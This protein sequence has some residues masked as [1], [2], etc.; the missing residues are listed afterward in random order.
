M[1]RLITDDE[2]KDAVATPPS[3]TRAYFRGMCLARFAARHRRRVV[4]LGDLRPARPRL[5]A[6][7]P[8][9]GAAA[10][11]QG[12]RR[13]LVRDAATPPAS[14]SRRI[15]VDNAS[16]ATRLPAANDASQRRSLSAALC[17][18][19][20]LLVSAALL[21]KS[22]PVEPH[23]E[24][25]PTPTTTMTPVKPVAEPVAPR[26]DRVVASTSPRPGS[27]TSPSRPASA[28]WHSRRT[29][30][31]P[32]ASP[33]SNRQCHVG[34]TTLAGIGAIESGHGTH[35][36]SRLHADGTTSRPILGPALD[37]SSGTARI[38]SDEQSEKVARRLQ[39]GTTPSGPMQFI[40]STWRKWGSDGN[41]RRHGRPQQ[42]R[43]TRPIRPA[44][45]C[46]PRAAT[47]GPARDGRRRSSPTTT[48]RTTC[49][50]S[51][52]APTRTSSRSRSVGR[53]GAV[54][55]NPA[56]P[57]PADASA[58]YSTGCQRRCV[59]ALDAT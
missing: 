21:A 28:R 34:W 50:A 47:C 48:P 39:A 10:R 42:R 54:S 2:I 53:A 43:S 11:H 25:A 58:G 44:A 20:G 19:A 56:R 33:A 24:P 31:R 41:A 29:R 15:T 40:P 36:G 1:D 22:P 55:W 12:A 46:A 59:P 4:G 3:D 7:H 16:V 6:A 9:D 5:A 35:G 32:Y 30:L 8:D 45:T 52:S 51:S 57:P 37:G 14:C 38:P 18:V 26:P 17:G 23:A 27:P 49:A 13:R